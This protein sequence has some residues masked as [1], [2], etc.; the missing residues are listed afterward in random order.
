MASRFLKFFLS[1]IEENDLFHKEK[2]KILLAVSGGVDSVVMVNAFAEN[3]L[4][5]G[6]AHCNFGL[7]GAESEADEG[8]VKALA[9]ELKVPFFVKKFN[10]KQFSGANKISTQMAA[11]DLRYQWFEEIRKENNYNFIATAHHKNDV[12]ETIL[13][14]LVKGT[15]LKGL[16][17]IKPKNKYIIRPL[18]WADKEEIIQFSKEQKIGYREDSSNIE[19]KYQRNLLRNEIIPLLKKINPDVINTIYENAQPRL[20]IEK[21]LNGQTNL[22]FQDLFKKEENGIL[23]CSVGA[24]KNSGINEAVFFQM[25]EEF[26]F[27]YSQV[28]NLFNALDETEHKVFNSAAYRLIKERS[29]IVITPLNLRAEYQNNSSLNFKLTGNN[30]VAEFDGKKL[31]ISNLKPQEIKD[32]KNPAHAFLDAEKLTFPLKIRLWQKGDY[33]YP[34]G[35]KG[36]KK[37]SDYFTDIKM[38]AFEKE[39]QLVLISGEDIAWI[40]GKRIDSRFRV[41]EVTEN[42]LKITLE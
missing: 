7:R 1:F 26:G 33:F 24:L 11:R 39:K 27:S 5:F 28:K 42:V 10:T 18:L 13:L 9:E 35:M 40:V 8:F 23:R 22:L 31:V 3:G 29:E 2:D 6:I 19:N 34:I 15:V 4:N 17:G 32:I 25:L 38:P 20:M 41:T 36:K 30:T 14:N 12:A 16:H 37:L 21:W